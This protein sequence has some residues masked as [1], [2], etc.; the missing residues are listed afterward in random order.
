MLERQIYP[1][2]KY[3]RNGPVIEPYDASGWTMSLQMGVKSYRLDTPLGDMKL[4]PLKDLAYP[5]KPF[6]GEGNYY[7]LPARFNRSVIVVNRLHKLGVKVFRYTYSGNG[8]AANPGDFLVRVSNLNESRLEALL[9]GTGVEAEKVNVS[10]S[11][12]LKELK[13]PRVGMYRSYQ[14]SMD[15]GWTRWILDHFEFDHTFILN[16]DF[17]DNQFDVKYDVVIIPDMGRDMIVKGVSSGYWA[18]YGKNMPP[19]FTGG[20]GKEGIAA[21]QALVKQGGTL[22]LLDS[23]SELGIKDFSLPF[24]NV[25]KDAKP[26]QFNCPGSLLRIE[27]DNSD[28]I[29]WGMEK[30][31]FIYFS[32]SPAF[33]TQ[34]PVMNHIDRNV[35]AGFKNIGPH[36]LSGYLKGGNLL[37]RA[38]TTL[39][40]K[41]YNGTV[42]ILGGRV[43]HRAQTYGTF[44]LLFNS[45]YYSTLK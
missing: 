34:V 26:D 16:K 31:S 42:I 18:R 19:K 13:P 11:Q 35:V 33:R 3:M 36:V 39:R 29:G 1:E 17:K 14:A 8:G 45:L 37:D 2:I 4:A 22:V 5:E 43:Q 10:V 38:V 40:F 21:L 12:H 20:I 28:P 9:K 44:K 32:R 15:E 6:R 25:L 27:V 7:L 24:T 30:E 23:A 41:Y